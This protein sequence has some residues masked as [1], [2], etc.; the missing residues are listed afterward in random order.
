MACKQDTAS[1][2]SAFLAE[3]NN[4]QDALNL[5][6]HC[7]HKGH[8]YLTTEAV[9]THTV[10]GN[11][12][13]T[14]P[15]TASA[16]IVSQQLP[17]VDVPIGKHRILTHALVVQEWHIYLDESFELAI[18]QS[19]KSNS[20]PKKIILPGVDLK[21]VDWSDT[22][23]IIRDLAQVLREK[24]AFLPYEEK[25]ETLKKLF[26]FISAKRIRER[27]RAHVTVRNA[28]AHHRGVIRHYDLKKL[29]LLS[30]GLV[31]TDAKGAKHRFQA[32]DKIT[33]STYDIKEL[34]EVATEHSKDLEDLT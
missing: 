18:T 23:S 33:L 14:L 4:H 21:R 32:D 8:E 34:V 15:K 12:Q 10:V 19:L 24:F 13:V 27:M 16:G 5:D 11:L 22:D 30:S 25:I 6:E 2:R 9:S 7:I 20:I 3:C 29:G 1:R 28:F 31:L 17:P 26:V